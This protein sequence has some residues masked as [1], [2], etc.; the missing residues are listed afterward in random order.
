[1]Q[2]VAEKIEW[3]PQTRYLGPAKVLEIDNRYDSDD[4]QVLN[5]A[6]DE[7]VYF[8]GDFLELDP[9][10]NTIVFTGAVGVTMPEVALYWRDTWY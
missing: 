9:G 4:L 2:S 3:I 6:V 7:I 10:V 1:M 5:N 8:E